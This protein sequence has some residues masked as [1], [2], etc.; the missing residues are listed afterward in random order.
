MA[1]MT[2]AASALPACC[3]PAAQQTCCD[4][5]DKHA[6]CDPAAASASCA[7]AAG[8]NAPDL[9]QTVRERYAAAAIAASEG[10]ARSCG[11]G[12]AIELVDAS[13]AVVVGGSLYADHDGAP[14]TAV[15]ASLGCGVP[16]AVADLH[17]GE[18]VL[19]LGSGAG[20]DVLIS[21]RRGVAPSSLRNPTLS[22][23]RHARMDS[24]CTRCRRPQSS[25][26]GRLWR[27]GSL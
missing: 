1:D 8:D 11:C 22:V 4:P 26:R 9:R 3:S 15:A 10:G 5:A 2:A 24:D 21:A 19:D 20:T 25:A 16:T 18:T 13:G 14:A 7:C 27:L 23:C 6:C 17:Q 12:S